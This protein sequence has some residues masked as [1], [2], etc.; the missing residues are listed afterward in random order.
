MKGVEA[1]IPFRPQCLF[2]VVVDAGLVLI[3]CPCGRC[4]LLVFRLI[5]CL[6]LVFF[7]SLFMFCIGLCLSSLALWWILVIRS[8]VFS[9]GLALCI[10]GVVR[11]DRI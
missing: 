5:S 10:V 2:L 6:F 9:V 8:F 1:K 7:S 3:C 11:F 4:C